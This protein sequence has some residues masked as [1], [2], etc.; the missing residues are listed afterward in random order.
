MKNKI[1]INDIAS[2]ANV[3]KTTVSFY[4][5]G[6]YEKMSEETRQRIE[7]VISENNYQPSSIARSLN[8]KKTNLLSVIIGDITNTFANQIVKGIEAYAHKFGYQL[9]ICSSGY[10]TE[11]EKQYVTNLNNLGVDG[12]IVQPTVHFREMYKKTGIDKPIVYFDSISSDVNDMWV[13]TNNTEAVKEALNYLITKGYEHY[14]LVTG[15]PSILTTRQERYNSFKNTLT[16]MNKSFE[17]VISNNNNDEVKVSEKLE[18]ILENKHNVAIFVVNCWLLST[19]YKT[20]KRH[21]KRIPNDIG[22]MGFDSL[23]WTEFSS[24]SI[25]TVV[26]PAYDEGYNAGELLINAIENKPIDNPNIILN[27]YINEMD[28]TLKDN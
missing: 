5:N 21:K 16:D 18:N 4:L 26:Q 2:L 13:K 28:S 25:T 15:D 27:C 3:S 24:P 11:I 22:L 14:V 23:E 9:I 17:I 20:V 6:K 7:K 10:D 1:T 8:F 19:V 12:F